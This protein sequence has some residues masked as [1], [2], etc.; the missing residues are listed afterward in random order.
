[1]P[2]ALI[3]ATAAALQSPAAIGPASPPK[4][5]VQFVASTPVPNPAPAGER[6]RITSR[7]LRPRSLG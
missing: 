7:R 2:T 6:P 4:T 1:M 5:I 3:L